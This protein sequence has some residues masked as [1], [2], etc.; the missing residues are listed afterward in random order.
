MGVHV[1]QQLCRVSLIIPVHQSLL[2]FAHA[3]HEA[4]LSAEARCSWL[5]VNLQ[6]HGFVFPAV[7]WPFWATLLCIGVWAVHSREHDTSFLLLLY[8]DIVCS[9]IHERLAVCFQLSDCICVVGIPLRCPTQAVLI[10]ISIADFLLNRS[11]TLK[12]G[13]SAGPTRPVHQSIA[14]W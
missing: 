12:K 6:Q 7:H 5:Y 2:H 14:L 1:K 3:A 10:C 4:L 9:A 8:T 11:H 13:V